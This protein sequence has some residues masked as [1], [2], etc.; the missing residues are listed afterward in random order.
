MQKK[1]IYVDT[2]ISLGTAGAE[3]DDGAAIILLLRNEK[4]KVAGVGSVF[5]NVPMQDATLNLDRLLTWL[6]GEDIPLGLG[7]AR[8]LRTD[9]TWF[10]EWQSGYE[11]TLDWTPRPTI[12]SSA[13]LIIKTIADNPNQ[14]SILA[15]GPLTN[16]AVALQLDPRIVSLT[17]EVIVM[18]GSFQPQNPTPEFNVRCDPEAAQIV[19]SA[20]WN[21][22]VLGLDLTR[23][24]H[25]S[26]QDFTSLPN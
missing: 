10:E 23:R 15:L 25:F 4:V 7:A 20:G 18:G 21:V 22:H 5:G 6:D 8:P 19:F 17:Q 3:I 9:M 1:L 24:V 12:S 2:D 14:V 11:K 16:L 13:D 26:R